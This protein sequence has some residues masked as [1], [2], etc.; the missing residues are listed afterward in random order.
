M[1]YLFLI[2]AFL[3]SGA[4]ASPPE[5]TRTIPPT[6]RETVRPRVQIAQPDP[7]STAGNVPPADGPMCSLG[8]EYA[9]PWPTHFAVLMAEPATEGESRM[10]ETQVQ[11]CFR[12][13][14]KDADPF[15]VLALYRYE[16]DVGV[17]AEARGIFGAIWCTENAL[18]MRSPRTGGPIRGDWEG[19][20]SGAH[21]PFQLH[22][23]AQ[24]SDKCGLTP[25]P[26]CKKND[27]FKEGGRD[28]L[29]ASAACWWSRV[30]F[31]LETPFVQSLKCKNPWPLAEALVANQGKYGADGCKAKSQH[32]VELQRWRKLVTVDK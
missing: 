20:W 28:D 8:E 16:E 30:L 2:S 13:H 26:D 11:K 7:A 4:Y 21:G 31:R 18:R 22:S 10:V 3:V 27:C 29:F 5:I 19:G 9:G 17:P 32:W 23:W 12:G 15:L 25:P 24:D 1:K 14:T 6:I